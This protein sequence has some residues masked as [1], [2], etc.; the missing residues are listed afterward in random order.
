MQN[1][2]NHRI[3]ERGRGVFELR[4]LQLGE[5]REGL[6]AVTEGLREGERVVVQGSF[7]LKAEFLK[8]TLEE[9]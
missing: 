6:I 4:H 7:I 2:R 3:V 1:V 8:G 9:E 5:E